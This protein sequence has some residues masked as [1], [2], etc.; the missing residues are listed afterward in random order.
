MVKDKKINNLLGGLWVAKKVH[1]ALLFPNQR[2]K[3]PKRVKH[4]SIFKNKP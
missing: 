1:F 3:L 4:Y 2:T